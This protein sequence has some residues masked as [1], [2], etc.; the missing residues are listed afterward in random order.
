MPCNFKNVISWAFLSWA[1]RAIKYALSF[2][3][4]VPKMSLPYGPYFF[5]IRNIDVPQSGHLPFIAVR[6]FFIVTSLALA[7]CFLPLHLTQ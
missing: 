1:N 7:I 6:P 3:V 4:V 5:I 2:E